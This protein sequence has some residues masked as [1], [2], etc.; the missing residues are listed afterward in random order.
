M[1]FATTGGAGTGE[2]NQLLWGAGTSMLELGGVLFST[3]LWGAVY[4]N[5]VE[6]SRGMPGLR[7]VEEPTMA[8]EP[9]AKLRALN[10]A[11]SGLGFRHD[12]WFSLDDFDETHVSAWRHDEH[13]AVGFVLYFPLSGAFRLRFVRRFPSGCVLSSSTRLT[14]LAYPPPPG[15]YVQAPN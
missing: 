14:D 6:A 7:S 10:R 15:V 13:P 11:L 8:P 4:L 3:L 2:W 9:A 5:V 12:G 1:G